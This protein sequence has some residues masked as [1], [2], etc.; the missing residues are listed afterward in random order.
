MSVREHL[1]AAVTEALTD[2]DADAFVHV[3]PTT[4]PETRY[5]LQAS[6]SHER[7]NGEPHH[8]RA[9]A[10]TPDI[11]L[12]CGPTA[13]GRHPAETLADRLETCLA[14]TGTDGPYTV[15]TPRTIPHDAVCYLEETGVSVTASDVLERARAVKTPAERARIA[16]AHGAA[17]TG[18][19]RGAALL[20]A[21]RVDADGLLRGGRDGGPLTATDLRLAVDEAVV[22][23]G[24]YPF[25]NTQVAVD[26]TLLPGETDLP[27]GTP[28]EISVT[29]REPGGYYG[30]LTRTVVVDGDGG[31]ERRA[32]VA[33]EAAFSSV[34]AY[35]SSDGPTVPGAEGDLEAEIRAFGFEEGIETEVTGIGLEPRETPPTE[36]VTGSVLRVA[37]SVA[38]PGGGR[39]GLADLVVCNANGARRLEGPPLSLEPEALAGGTTD[40]G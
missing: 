34:R 13:D 10:F 2:R 19:E 9:M 22:R 24:T 6:G 38:G 21:A 4:A 12:Q 33:A 27:G 15:L 26:G 31:W 40:D 29:P 7:A 32:A 14:A 30:S 39:V 18:L 11:L 20:A 8:T 17:T 3:G 25:A 5:C 36:D 16:H 1:Q 23:A 35:L 28:I 37:A